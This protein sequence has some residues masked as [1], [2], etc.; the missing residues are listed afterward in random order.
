MKKI[1]KLKFETPCHFGAAELGGRLES[2]SFSY[3]SDVLF[4]A[5]CCEFADDKKVADFFDTVRRGK[6]LFSDLLPY[7]GEKFFIPK[8][9]LLIDSDKTSAR[10][11]PGEMRRRATERKKQKKIEFIRASRLTKYFSA[12][13]NNLPFSE[14]NNF[15]E[16]IL[17]QKVSCREEKPLPYFVGTFS[18]N[19]G[20]GFY[21]IA[22]FDDEETAEFFEGILQS[23][24]LS[25]IGGKKSSGLGKF[26]LSEVIALDTATK[27]DL[28]ALN[29][30]LTDENSA[31]QMNLSSLIPTADE[32][33]TLKNSFFKLKRRG[34]FVSSNGTSECKKNNVC[35]VAAGS[36][37]RR[38]LVGD[39][40][41]L[42]NVDGHEIFRL[43]R[44]IYA[45]L[46]I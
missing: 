21:L 33:P 35:V 38:R 20:S 4:G 9:I 41:S 1:Y 34:G 43:G 46:T 5:L 18:F 42:G 24:G 31:W 29:R 11:D 27:D 39:I 22:L 7:N 32:I 15:G 45:G 40:V 19:E 2:V 36:C 28:C 16:T 6:I 12:L 44:S 23:L 17:L 13:K 10:L 26:S 3:A 25:G 37:F 8:P 14:E 30:M